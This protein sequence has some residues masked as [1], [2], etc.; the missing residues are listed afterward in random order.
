MTFN[1]ETIV[2]KAV[3]V[4]K[5]QESA[6]PNTE[7]VTEFMS[8]GRT[9]E[10][11]VGRVSGDRLSVVARERGERGDEKELRLI[12]DRQSWA[13]LISSVQQHL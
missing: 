8:N 6:V 5:P 3:N 11:Q 7:G 12:L 10:V 9:L 13:D 1:L 2:C 4:N